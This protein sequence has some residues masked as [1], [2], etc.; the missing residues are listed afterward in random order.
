MKKEKAGRREAQLA[1]QPERQKSLP[2]CNGTCEGPGNFTLFLITLLPSHHI[3]KHLLHH[4]LS[5]LN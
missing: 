2:F 3:I 4:I 5:K 1:S